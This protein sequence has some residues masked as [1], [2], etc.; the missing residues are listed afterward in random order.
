MISGL[1]DLVGFYGEMENDGAS[2]GGLLEEPW[3]PGRMPGSLWKSRESYI[4]NSP[5]F[6]L[7]RVQTP[8]LILHGASDRNAAP[9]LGDQVFVFLR[10][11]GKDVV[12]AKYRGEGHAI[13]GYGDQLDYCDRIITWFDTHLKT[14][15]SQEDNSTQLP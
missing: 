9:F 8:L 12:Y 6:Y 15:A 4:E 11:L 14:A 5:I 7:D 10:R 3:W 1:G 2:L 13:S